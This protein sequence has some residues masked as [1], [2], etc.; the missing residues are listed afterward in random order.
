MGAPVGGL[1]QAS[2][3]GPGVDDA[4]VP[5]NPGNGSQAVP[6]RADVAVLKSAVLLRVDGLGWSAPGQTEGKPEGEEKEGSS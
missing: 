5:G 6:G 2:R 4:G 1:P 3:G